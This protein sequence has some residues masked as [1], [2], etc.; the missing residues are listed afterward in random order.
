MN[1]LHQ[2]RR[3]LFLFAGGITF[4]LLFSLLGVALGAT[5][6]Q[7]KN[8]LRGQVK[9]LKER[10]YY[11]SSP[12]ALVATWEYDRMGRETQVRSG[13]EREGVPIS[14]ITATNFFD[15]QGRKIRQ[16]R[17]W[18]KDPPVQYHQETLYGYDDQGN[19]SVEAEYDADGSFVYLN[20]REYDEQGNCIQAYQYNAGGSVTVSVERVEYQY[21]AQEQ[22]VQK[23]FWGDD[24]TKHIHRYDEK[25]H[26]VKTLAYTVDGH[27]DG[28]TKYDYDVFGNDLESRTIDSKGNLISHR[29]YTYEYDTK[30]NWIKKISKWLIK[31]GKPFDEI[32]I[33]ERTITYYDLPAS[34]LPN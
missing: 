34:P 30:K 12:W 19:Q 3:V 25:G 5:C 31:E 6:F 28:E 17:S 11:I 15:D 9:T 24:G 8:D 32:G 1:I 16:T 20:F 21:D 4:T 29:T 27:F 14:S 7:A 33:M 23:I 2:I 26:V 18:D 10:Q 13:G 22:T